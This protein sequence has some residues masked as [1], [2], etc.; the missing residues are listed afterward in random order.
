MGVHLNEQTKASICLNI[1]FYFDRR[2]GRVA[3]FTKSL[4]RV[5]FLCVHF[6]CIALKVK[7]FK[8]QFDS[9]ETHGS[10]LLMHAYI[11]CKI[12]SITY[13]GFCDITLQILKNCFFFN[14]SVNN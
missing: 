13:N 9:V 10:K 14:N 8:P 11:E 12:T 1:I 2:S 6:F 7:S 5:L 4:V 3:R